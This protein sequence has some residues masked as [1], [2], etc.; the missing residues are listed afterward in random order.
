[1]WTWLLLAPPAQGSAVCPAAG[2]VLLIDTPAHRMHLCH[3]GRS[4]AEYA[5]S[6]GFGGTGKRRE[7][8]NRTPLGTYSLGSG[9]T[10]AKFHL[11]LPIGYPSAE[12]RQRGLT[13]GDVGIHGPRR[14]PKSQ[15]R[16]LLL[17]LSRTLDWTR[18]CVAVATDTEIEDVAARVARRHIKSVILR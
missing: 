11:F 1:M 9:R 3:Q 8:D 15:V 18:G 16:G 12:Q 6:L 2:S 5:V 4:E 13:G 14:K 10:S 17:R 7:G